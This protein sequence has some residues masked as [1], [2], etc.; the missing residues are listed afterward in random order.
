MDGSTQTS[1]TYD[2]AAETRRMAME[3]AIRC[4]L[5][6]VMELGGVVATASAIEKYLS[7]A[8]KKN[9]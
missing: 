7:G 1:L 5:Q 6:I 8:E 3:L 9:D 2:P 4:N